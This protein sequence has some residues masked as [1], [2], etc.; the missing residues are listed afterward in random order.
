MAFLYR[1]LIGLYQKHLSPRK[2]YRCAYSL[3]HGGTGCSGAVLHILE[4][5]GLW[6]GWSLI[7]KRFDECGNAAERRK[8]RHKKEKKKDRDCL[9]QASCDGLSCPD[10]CV[11]SFKK[12]D[13][14]DL[15]DCGDCGGGLSIGLKDECGSCKNCGFSNIFSRRN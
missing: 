4:E 9:P 10:N 8:E 12:C 7:H 6:R 15:P 14:P 13:L 1:F 2:G 5:K 3:E 11:P